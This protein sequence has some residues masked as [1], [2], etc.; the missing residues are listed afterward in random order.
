MKKISF[1][2]RIEIK[3]DQNPFISQSELAYQV[4]LDSIISGD[5]EIGEKLNQE[6]LSK[7]LDMSRT[8]VRDALIRLSNEK[9]IS[10]GDNNGSYIHKID[11][12]DYMEFCEFRIIIEETAAYYAARSILDSQ[13]EELKNILDRY[14]EA[15]NKHNG[16]LAWD[17]D[18]RFHSLIIQASRNSYII[19]AYDNISIKRKIYISYMKSIDDLQCAKKKHI[20]IYN[21]INSA[22]ENLAKDSMHSHLS[23]YN[24]GIIKFN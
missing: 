22:D 19:N 12:K 20:A 5:I 13:L 2:R 4:L 11:I 14:V 8:P 7:Q 1:G 10:K 3:R 15:C 21:A 24:R 18:D 9:I 23:W 17:L 6:E 16:D